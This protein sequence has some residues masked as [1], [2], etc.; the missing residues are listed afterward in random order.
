MNSKI[1]TLASLLVG[2]YLVGV[3]SAEGLAGAEADFRVIQSEMRAAAR[4][5]RR[6]AEP[7]YR[8]ECTYYTR[9]TQKFVLLIKGDEVS[10]LH[11]GHWRHGKMV[12]RVSGQDPNT[13]RVKG[14][15][16]AENDVFVQTRMFSGLSG[17]TQFLLTHATCVRSEK[18]LD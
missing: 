8:F 2:G 14:L 6:E 15:W 18:K 4:E 11:H 17:E 10:L 12:P 16:Y 3:G 7:V 5:A 9:V 13:R 1:L